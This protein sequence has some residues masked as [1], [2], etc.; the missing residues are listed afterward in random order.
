MPPISPLPYQ[1]TLVFQ[2]LELMYAFKHDIACAE[3]YVERDMIAF[4]GFFTQEQVDLAI[5]KYNA[6]VVK[7]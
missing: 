2:S 1:T 4:V 5:T 6:G 7:S 3:F